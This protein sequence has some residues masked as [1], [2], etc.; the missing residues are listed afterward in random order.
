[1]AL[2]RNGELYPLH[3]WSD[4]EIVPWCIVL[5]IWRKWRLNTENLKNLQLTVWKAKRYNFSKTSLYYWVYES[6]KVS[7]IAWVFPVHTENELH[8]QLWKACCLLWFCR[9]TRSTGLIQ[10]EF[11]SRVFIHL[12][13]KL[14]DCLSPKVI[15]GIVRDTHLVSILILY[16]S[17]NGTQGLLHAKQILYLWAICSA[18]NSNAS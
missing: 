18:P 2:E 4:G 17:G 10:H 1:M 15:W 8:T 16:P 14:S 13:L 12:R 6:Q 9:L 7:S 3:N 5:Q 11:P